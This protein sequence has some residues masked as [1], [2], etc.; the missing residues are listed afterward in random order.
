VDQGKTFWNGAKLPL[1]MIFPAAVDLTKPSL[2]IPN[3]YNRSNIIEIFRVV[4][5]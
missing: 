2:K 3:F 5:H 1:K 4:V